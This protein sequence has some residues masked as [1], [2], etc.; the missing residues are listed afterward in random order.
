MEGDEGK[1]R[2]GR[3]EAAEQGDLEGLSPP[4]LKVGS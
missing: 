2:E 1:V 3:A 4:L